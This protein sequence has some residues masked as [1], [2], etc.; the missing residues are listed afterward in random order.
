MS[1]VLAS[2]WVVFT[3]L[4]G[5]L[6][7]HHDYQAAPALPMLTRLQADGIAVVPATSKT[8][9]ELE[10]LLA[11]LP[12][13]GA[14]IVENGASVHLPADWPGHELFESAI[15]YATVLTVLE[16][17]KPRFRFRGFHDLGVEGIARETGLS[18]AQA[19]LAARR[20]ASEPV[21][22]QDTDSALAEFSAALV[23]AGLRVIRGGRF[24][25]VLGAQ[26]DKAHS[27]ER[28]LA[29]LHRR[30]WRGRSLALGDAPNDHAMLSRADV[31]VVVRNPHSPHMPDLGNK[32]I[33]QTQETGPA[34][35]AEAI[36]HLI[37]HDT[38]ETDE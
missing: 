10:L 1:R 21:L 25:H 11:R 12:L 2:D 3:D 32:R 28:M 24:V 20:Q 34:G 8:R 29:G 6:L 5:T 17:L 30:G 19:T 23:P 9:A 38:G 13:S 15:D 33:Y 31:A 22:W 7:D 4:D 14:A 27:V 18:L 37:Y 26:A 16:G 36:G 35:W